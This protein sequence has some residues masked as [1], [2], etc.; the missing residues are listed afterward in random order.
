LAQKFIS[1]ATLLRVASSR[2]PI[3][4]GGVLNALAISSTDILHASTSWA[5][6]LDRLIG[7]Y[8]IAEPSTGMGGFFGF[9]SRPFSGRKYPTNVRHM[10]SY[11]DGKWAKFR[12]F[13]EMFDLFL[14]KIDPI[15]PVTFDQT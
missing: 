9:I 15:W 5:S 13:A 11:L 10:V 7:L 1:D 12:Q 8:F 14:T 6:W 4:G 2:W 3:N